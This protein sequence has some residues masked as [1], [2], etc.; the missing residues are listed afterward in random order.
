METIGTIKEII[1]YKLFLL[2]TLELFLFGLGLFELLGLFGLTGDGDAGLLWLG[3]SIEEALWII[4]LV[5][6]VDLYESL[7]ATI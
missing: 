7:F 5:D 1:Q 4:Y 6:P 2:K 3:S